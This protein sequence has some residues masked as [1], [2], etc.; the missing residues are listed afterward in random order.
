MNFIRFILILIVVLLVP[1]AAAS[2]TDDKVC[3]S[4]AASFFLTW[5][6]V[7]IGALGWGVAWYATENDEWDGLE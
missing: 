3:I 1:Y 2:Q 4:Q 5:G 7:V 6:A